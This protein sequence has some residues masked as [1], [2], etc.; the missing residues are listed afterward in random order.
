MIRLAGMEH[1][2][3]KNLS[4]YRLCSTSFNGNKKKIPFNPIK[5][6]E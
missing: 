4:I 1:M 2:Q 5:D 6:Q 3:T